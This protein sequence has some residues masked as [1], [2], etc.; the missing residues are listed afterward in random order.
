MGVSDVFKL[1]I[2]VVFSGLSEGF[3]QA[4]ICESKWAIEAFDPA[5]KAYRLNFPNATVFTDDCNALLRQVMDVS[6]SLL[7]LDQ[8]F[9]L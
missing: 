2:D 8:G 1:G 6:T 5:A 3:H 7:L 9:F 4:G